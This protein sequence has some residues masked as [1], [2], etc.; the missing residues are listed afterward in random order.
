MRCLLVSMVVFT[1]MGCE[2][3]PQ[4]YLTEEQDATVAQ[5]CADGCVIIPK[6]QFEQLPRLLCNK[7]F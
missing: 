1:L 3:K 2:Q 7:S 5:Q 6:A 4:R